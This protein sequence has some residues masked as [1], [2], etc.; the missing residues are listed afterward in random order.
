[1]APPHHSKRLHPILQGL[2]PFLECRPGVPDKARQPLRLIGQR[3]LLRRESRS[4]D[5]RALIQLCR[6]KKGIICIPA[7]RRRSPQTN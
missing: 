5:R 4:A 3:T 7:D 6:T 2:N 1:M